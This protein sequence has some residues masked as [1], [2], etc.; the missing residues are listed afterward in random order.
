MITSYNNNV[1]LQTTNDQPL[2]AQAKQG[3]VRDTIECFFAEKNETQ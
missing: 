2:V 3:G 1:S